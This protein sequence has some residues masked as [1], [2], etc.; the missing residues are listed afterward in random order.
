[1]WYASPKFIKFVLTRARVC[2]RVYVALELCSSCIYYVGGGACDAKKGW[3]RAISP[4]W[5]LMAKFRRPTAVHVRNYFYTR[6]SRVFGRF[7]C[8]I[9]GGWEIALP[10]YN[11]KRLTGG[12]SSSFWCGISFTRLWDWGTLEQPPISFITAETVLPLF[13]SSFRLRDRDVITRLV[14][15]CVSVVRVNCSR[16]LHVRDGY[17]QRLMHAF[18]FFVGTPSRRVVLRDYQDPEMVK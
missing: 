10:Y 11:T 6:M 1:M 3:S 14:C 9:R 4:R 17:V 15:V 7:C 13:A 5:H 12:R 18:D 8:C 16:Q 2:V